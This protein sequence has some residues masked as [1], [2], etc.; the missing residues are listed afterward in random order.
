M[1]TETPKKYTIPDSIFDM[2]KRLCTYAGYK[3]L[4]DTTLAE[5][6]YA[7]AEDGGYFN[8]CLTCRR[9][10]TG[11]KRMVTCMG[12][13]TDEVTEKIRKDKLEVNIPA[14]QTIQDLYT[15]MNKQHPDW[16][17]S[18]TSKDVAIAM[19]F[20]M[21]SRVLKAQECTPVVMQY[22]TLADAMGYSA[23]DLAFSPEEYAAELKK[24]ADAYDVIVK[25][26][27]GLSEESSTGNFTN[28]PNNN[29]GEEYSFKTVKLVPGGWPVFLV[30]P[31][32]D[33][34]NKTYKAGQPGQELTIPDKFTGQLVKWIANDKLEFIRQLQTTEAP[35]ESP[36]DGYSPWF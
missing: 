8:E 29:I 13:R 32:E 35:K 26:L 22:L 36:H 21:T 15:E 19:T 12:C 5:R 33:N 27:S 4:K 17:A 25:Q 14:L 1:T 28:L 3:I 34:V 2:M 11:F 18:G 20:D 24:K 7:K 30:G 9:T 23:G 6:S 10:F 16:N 31:T